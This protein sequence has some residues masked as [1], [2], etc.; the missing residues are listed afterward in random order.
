VWPHGVDRSALPLGGKEKISRARRPNGRS[1]T[2]LSEKQRA[3]TC[4]SQRTR[5]QKRPTATGTPFEP[6]AAHPGCAHVHANDSE[7][8]LHSMKCL[9]RIS[10]EV[11]RAESKSVREAGIG[12]DS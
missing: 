11:L 2:G 4:R 7:R 3:V 10:G 8:A 5:C 1:E 9:I 12:I 6:L